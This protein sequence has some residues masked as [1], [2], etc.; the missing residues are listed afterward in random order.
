MNA[1]G[2]A[3]QAAVTL[4]VFCFEPGFNVSGELAL[5]LC[6]SGASPRPAKFGSEADGGAQQADGEQPGSKEDAD[7]DGGKV[8]VATVVSPATQM[9]GHR[10][11]SGYTATCR[12]S[13]ASTLHA[14]N[15]VHLVCILPE[16]AA[17]RQRCTTWS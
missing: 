8:Q 7:A 11:A 16:G 5:M 12:A 4:S 10:Q 1:C 17:S 14:S 15:D 2:L 6:H 13:F 3:I 9:D